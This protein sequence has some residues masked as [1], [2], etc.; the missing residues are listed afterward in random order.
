MKVTLKPPNSPTSIL[1]CWVI[2]H[3]HQAKKVGKFVEVTGKFDVN[4]WY[5]HQ[6]HSKT[7]V[8]T[9]CVSY[10]ERIRLHYRDEPTSGHEEI[11]VNVIQHPNCTEAI[12]SECG[13]KFIITVERELIA[14]VIGETKICVL[15][16][17]NNFEEEWPFRD[18][19]SSL[20]QDHGHNHNHGESAREQRRVEA[21]VT[22][23]RRQTWSWTRSRKRQRYTILL[24]AGKYLPAFFRGFI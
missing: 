1:G 11:I 16:H 5:S 4:V 7:S 12:I 22:G 9:E 21:R 20:N 3:T 23:H 10:K 24:R 15:V 18:E 2:N 14:E 19:S 8:F 17:E 6:D 13:E